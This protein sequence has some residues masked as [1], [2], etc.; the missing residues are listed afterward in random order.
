MET[1]DWH[2]EVI[3]RQTPVTKSYRNTQNVR[4]FM[5]VECG[6]K[7]KFDRL[8][9]AWIGDGTPKTMGDVADEWRRRYVPR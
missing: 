7:F 3:D 5:A 4:R 9:M 1:F 2:S 6:P 8:F